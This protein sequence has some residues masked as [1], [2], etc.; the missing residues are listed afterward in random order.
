TDIALGVP[1]T[2][3]HE[4]DGCPWRPAV[5]RH[6]NALKTS[7]RWV[8]DV[9]LR[10][11]RS[12]HQSTQS[13]AACLQPGGT[14]SPVEPSGGKPGTPGQSVGTQAAV[15]AR[16]RTGRFLPRLSPGFCLSFFIR[17]GRARR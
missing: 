6:I 1:S 13:L 9:L 17:L 14:G 12:V 16:R 10:I 11:W 15:H 8:S 2:L 3:G 7:K 5:L 4:I